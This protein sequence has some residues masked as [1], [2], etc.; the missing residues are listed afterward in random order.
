[1][2]DYKL[3]GSNPQQHPLPGMGGTATGERPGQGGHGNQGQGGQG[4]VMGSIGET[5]QNV[6]E[7]AQRVVGQARETVGQ[8]ASN[9]ADTAQEQFESFN[10]MVRRNPVPA[11]LIAGGIGLLLGLA[12]A[13]GA[14][15]FSGP[16]YGRRW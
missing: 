16:S 11:L 10:E 15:S 7:G 8:Y 12:L 6:A 4:G 14:A 2:A 5:A 9:V 1:M 3:G 13:G